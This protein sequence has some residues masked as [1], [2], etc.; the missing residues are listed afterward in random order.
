ML[1]KKRSYE[2]VSK[3]VAH[4]TRIYIVAHEGRKFDKEINKKMELKLESMVE[5]THLWAVLQNMGLVHMI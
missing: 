1:V 3:Q 2:K 5:K 4:K